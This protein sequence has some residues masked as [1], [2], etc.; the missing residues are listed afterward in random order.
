MFFPVGLKLISDISI[1]LCSVAS[2]AENRLLGAV[3]SSPGRFDTLNLFHQIFFKS[4]T[5]M[6]SK[7]RISPGSI[8]LTPDI[9][10]ISVAVSERIILK[11]FHFPPPVAVSEQ[12]LL[13]T[14]QLR[15][16]SY[17]ESL[18]NKF[19]RLKDRIFKGSKKALLAYRSLKT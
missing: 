6:Q 1:R 13:K 17:I 19:H 2:I 3:I 7:I 8:C 10:V 16:V 11:L 14:L 4:S 15:H 9:L 5:I 18:T 12:I